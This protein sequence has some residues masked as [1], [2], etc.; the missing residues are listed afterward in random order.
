MRYNI[1]IVSDYT[2]N[3]I[4]FFQILYFCDI[5]IVVISY[6]YVESS[7]WRPAFGLLE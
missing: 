5:T 1:F 7:E 4:Y 2:Y 3:I 6:L